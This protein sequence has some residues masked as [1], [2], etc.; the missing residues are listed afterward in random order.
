M[1]HW[2]TKNKQKNSITQECSCSETRG[3]F[4]WDCGTV[5]P[6]PAVKIWDCG[7]VVPRPT[8]KIW[9]CGTVV[10]R[11]TV[12]IWDC[13]TV[14]PR[15]AVKNCCNNDWSAVKR[16]N[17]NKRRVH[18]LNDETKEPSRCLRIFHRCF[19]NHFVKYD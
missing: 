16:E 10:P 6:L 1:K 4:F 14:V 3:Q 13:G 12:K 19:I 7:T 2:K 15:P 8:V 5:V 17:R 9:D 18:Q 11:P